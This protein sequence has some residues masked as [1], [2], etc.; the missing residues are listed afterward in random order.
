MRHASDGAH[1]EVLGRS[2]LGGRGIVL[3]ISIS[4]MVPAFVT[5]KLG[6]SLEQTPGMH[7]SE[8]RCTSKFFN[9]SESGFIDA[10]E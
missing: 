2:R 7:G 6:S 5:K 4:Y 3:F 10:K 8:V 9:L 1:A